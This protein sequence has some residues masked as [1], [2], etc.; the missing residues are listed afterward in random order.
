MA[1]HDNISYLLYLNRLVHQYNNTYHHY[2]NK[3][4]TNADYSA[5]TERLRPIVELL[6]LKLMIELELLS[7]RKF[8]VKVILKIG[9]EKFIIY[10][11]LKTSTWTYK[12]KY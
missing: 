1:A 9:Q 7:I 3:I 12:I 5:F 4:L 11:L 10:S 6:S 2:I 8:L